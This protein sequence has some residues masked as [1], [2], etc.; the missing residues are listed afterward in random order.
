ME[1]PR[2][3]VDAGLVAF[4]TAAIFFIQKF[5]TKSRELERNITELKDTIKTFCADEKLHSDE[6][7]AIDVRLENAAGY[8]ENQ[9]ELL[10]EVGKSQADSEDVLK[11]LID[12][13][14]EYQRNTFELLEKVQKDQEELHNYFAVLD[15]ELIL[16]VSQ[17]DTSITTIFQRWEQQLEPF[18]TTSEKEHHVLEDD[19]ETLKHS[20]QELADNICR[21]LSQCNGRLATASESIAEHRDQYARDRRLFTPNHHRPYGRDT[22]SYRGLQRQAAYELRCGSHGHESR[23][24]RRDYGP[25][26]QEPHNRPLVDTAYEED[27]EY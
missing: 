7:K 8:L 26:R 12:K 10:I 23:P 2:L 16:K 9:R 13:N 1:V 19:F 22:R 20:F 5:F 21:E 24:P 15:N 14:T 6:R 11:T 17:I 3:L 27:D 18:I 25:V 4:S